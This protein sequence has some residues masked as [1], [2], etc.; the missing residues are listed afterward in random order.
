MTIDFNSSEC[1]LKSQAH[2]QRSP[3][4]T[5]R[6]NLCH[7]CLLMKLVIN[8]PSIRKSLTAEYLHPWEEFC[9]SAGYH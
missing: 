1:S 4:V 6:I 2:K 3:I 8:Y 5:V 7:L 9:F